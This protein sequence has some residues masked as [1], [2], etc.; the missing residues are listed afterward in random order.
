[1][2]ANEFI[3]I[4]DK[5]NLLHNLSIMTKLS[6]KTNNHVTV[7]FA[8]VMIISQRNHAK[9]KFFYLSSKKEEN[10]FLYR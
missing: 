2:D 8:I 1:M 4:C 10:V 7:W 3:E 5:S 9:D 6:F